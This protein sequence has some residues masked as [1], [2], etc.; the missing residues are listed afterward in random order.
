MGFANIVAPK[1]CVFI[2]K[3]SDVNGCRAEARDQAHE[4]I[5]TLEQDG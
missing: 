2:T 5:R 1:L 4:F 3:P